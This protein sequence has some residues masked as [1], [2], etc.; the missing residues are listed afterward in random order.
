MGDK[1]TTKAKSGAQLYLSPRVVGMNPSDF[2]RYSTRQ[3]TSKVTLPGKLSVK[4]D[5]ATFDDML[6]RKLKKK[7]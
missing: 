5:R 1:K 6:D 2:A 4:E 7:R 3:I